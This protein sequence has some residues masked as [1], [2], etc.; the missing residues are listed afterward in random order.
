MSDIMRKPDCAEDLATLG[1]CVLTELLALIE[2][3]RALSKDE[4]GRLHVAGLV[5]LAS[6]HA[7]EWADHFSEQA[8]FLRE[9]NARAGGG[10]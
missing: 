10:A 2:G 8:E 5:D 6:R 4:W 9:A 3:I 7:T 1:S